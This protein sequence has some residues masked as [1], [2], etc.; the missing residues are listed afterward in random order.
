MKERTVTI[1]SI[2]LEAVDDKSIRFEVECSSGTYIRSL[3][4]DIGCEIGSGAVMTALTRESVGS[5][6]SLDATKLSETVT[7]DDIRS[8]SIVSMEQFLSHFPSLSIKASQYDHLRN[9]KPIDELSLSLEEGYN[10]LFF[11]KSPKFL[12]QKQA[13]D[14]SYVAYL[15]DE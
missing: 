14:L 9:G 12:L 7:R 3:I 15:G 11:E 2:R 8:E 10:L 5:Y 1:H 13:S 6:R 4:H